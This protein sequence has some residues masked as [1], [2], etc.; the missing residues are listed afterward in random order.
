MQTLA[1]IFISL[2][3]QIECGLTKSGRVAH[4]SFSIPY[5][6]ADVTSGEIL[7]F[8][9]ILRPVLTGRITRV[10]LV[11]KTV[12]DVWT[13]EMRV[14]KEEET[15]TSMALKRQM[16]QD[17]EMGAAGGSNAA[18]SANMAVT[19]APVSAAMPVAQAAILAEEKPLRE[20][21]RGFLP[22]WKEAAKPTCMTNPAND[23]KAKT[24]NE[25]GFSLPVIKHDAERPQEKR[26]ALKHS[27]DFLTRLRANDFKITRE[28]LD[29]L[30]SW[31]PHAAGNT[32]AYKNHLTPFK[33]LDPLI[34]GAAPP[35]Q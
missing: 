2:V 15:L 30:L 16:R 10:N 5:I 33:D 7:A 19:G 24:E 13:P 28:E 17:A 23:A 25:P 20:K 29:A 21:L 26:E 3:I 9:E 14:V 11:T 34:Y 22:N 32:S 1:K 27:P 31:S 4:K 18:V 35:G 12:Y 6:R 8:I